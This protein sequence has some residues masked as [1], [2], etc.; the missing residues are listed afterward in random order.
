M[1][2]NPSRPSICRV[3]AFFDAQ[4]LFLSTKEC[5]GYKY[6][7]Y[8]PIK[9]AQKITELEENRKLIKV[10]FYTGVHEV[11][12]NEFLHHFWM[13]KLQGLR[14]AGVNVYYRF[15]KYADY[16]KQ[17]SS[18][19]FETITKP[20]EKGVDIKLAIDLIKFAR[21]GMYDIAII[22]SQ[23]TD[24]NEAVNE[25][26][27]IRKEFNRWIRLEC[28]FPHSEEMKKQRG[29]DNT[30]W[31]PITK[32]LYDQCIDERDYRPKPKEKEPNLF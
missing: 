24:L 23:D 5:F 27:E 18:G 21:K 32:E 10:N 3:H 8:D 31:R 26:Y 13:N 2:D 22:F 30:Q 16:K 19:D 14:R 9:L 11:N 1:S 7:N 25:I 6:P 28:A 12:R 4:N 15:L 29:L 17:T 20:R